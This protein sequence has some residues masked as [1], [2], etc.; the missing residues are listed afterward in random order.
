LILPEYYFITLVQDPIF[1][2]REKKEIFLG[3]IAISG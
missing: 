1:N 3:E 2:V